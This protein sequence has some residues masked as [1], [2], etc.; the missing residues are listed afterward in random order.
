MALSTQQSDDGEQRV[1]KFA[2]VRGY[3]MHDE[4]SMHL[5]SLSPSPTS[6]SCLDRPSSRH[7]AD[8]MRLFQSSVQLSHPVC[9]ERPPTEG[10]SK[11]VPSH[12]QKPAGADSNGR[13]YIR[14]SAICGIRHMVATSNDEIRSTDRLSFSKLDAR[15][16]SPF[17]KRTNSPSFATDDRDRFG[18]CPS[19]RSDDCP[20]YVMLR[21]RRAGSQTVPHVSTPRALSRDD[22]S[23][24][25]ESPRLRA[26][27][28]AAV[29]KSSR[30]SR[31]SKNMSG[32]G[33]AKAL[34]QPSIM[35][36]SWEMSRNEFSWEDVRAAVGDPLDSEPRC[37][38]ADPNTKPVSKPRLGTRLAKQSVV[39][40]MVDWYGVAAKRAA[41]PPPR[42]GFVLR[43]DG[44]SGYHFDVVSRDEP[45]AFSTKRH[46]AVMDI[47][48]DVR[49]R[50][51][52]DT[53]R[54]KRTPS[55]DDS[56][57]E[58]QAMLCHFGVPKLSLVTGTARS[59]SSSSSRRKASTQP[60]TIS[61]C[62]SSVSRLSS[63]CL[64][65]TDVPGTGMTTPDSE[66]ASV[67]SRSQRPGDSRPSHTPFTMSRQTW[68]ALTPRM[69]NK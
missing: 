59:R 34:Q 29:G 46:D 33:V 54:R 38:H 12:M 36:A 10:S 20:D 5:S 30:D 15:P 61:G 56:E 43:P 1:R 35:T 26:E 13:W 48:N 22:R 64:S 49:R 42:T 63:H 67:W 11:V 18:S 50:A 16:K 53:P 9:P 57:D 25:H 7:V 62:H 37:V 45:D 65:V 51:A 41:R 44:G 21:A 27:S 68:E 40:A 58:R 19:S 2:D 23:I 69:P 3:A 24:R 66:L 60:S 17:E 39:T 28:S 14:D 47:V 55:V 8:Q 52:S 4:G 6:G 31:C 32:E